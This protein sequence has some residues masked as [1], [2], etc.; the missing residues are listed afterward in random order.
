MQNHTGNKKHICQVCDASFTKKWSL[1]QH[2]TT[3]EVKDVNSYQCEYCD[4]VARSKNRLKSHL[5]SNHVDNTE[6]KYSCGECPSEFKTDEEL[7]NHIQSSHHFTLIS[8]DIS[9]TGLDDC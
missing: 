4:Y 1:K 7:R 8:D 9:Y 6:F 2:L 5:L 3:H